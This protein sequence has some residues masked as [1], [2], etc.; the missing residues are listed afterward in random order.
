MKF[1]GYSI[2]AGI[3]NGTVTFDPE[4]RKITEFAPAFTNKLDMFDR[5]VSQIEICRDPEA[6]PANERTEIYKEMDA[7]AKT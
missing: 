6:Y 4:T 5:A 2:S 3:R 7:R 1:N